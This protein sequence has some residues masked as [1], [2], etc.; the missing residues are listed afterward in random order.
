MLILFS[1][2]GK[3]R[4]GVLFRFSG[5]KALFEKESLFLKIR[6]SSGGQWNA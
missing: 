5:R 3:V 4:K 6:E 2:S 1:A